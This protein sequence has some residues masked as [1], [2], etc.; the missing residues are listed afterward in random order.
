M[1][2]HFIKLVYTQIL[3][4]IFL[5]TS[6]FLFAQ[7]IATSDNLTSGDKSSN[8]S[9]LTSTNNRDKDDNKSSISSNLTSTNNR[10]KNDDKSSNSSNLTSTNNRDKNDNKT[11]GVS[12]ESSVNEILVTG[13]RL[14]SQASVDMPGVNIIT[15]DDIENIQPTSV[16]SLLRTLPS[17]SI[18]EYGAGK[19]STIR[20]RGALSEHTL[21]MVD[22][23][24]VND[25]TNI[26]NVADLSTLSL[27]DIE[28][29]EVISDSVSSVGF[30]GMGGVVNI[31]TKK[32]DGKLS[33]TVHLDTSVFLDE[34]NGGASIGAGNDN[35]SYKVSYSKLY[36]DAMSVLTNTA[37]DNDPEI[38]AT[39]RD[40]VVIKI[41]F[42]PIQHFK[43]EFVL[44]YVD[45]FA[46]IDGGGSPNGDN[47][48]FT[49]GSNR[50]ATK[51]TTSYLIKDMFEPKLSFYYTYNQREYRDSF[52]NSSFVFRNNDYISHSAGVDFETN[53]KI[54][55]LFKVLVGTSYQFNM[56][57]L[58]TEESV[59]SAGNEVYDERLDI[60]G[61][62]LSRF[63]V[64][65]EAQA[66]LF[67][68]LTLKLS[69]RVDNSGGSDFFGTYK[70]SALYNLKYLR[71]KFRGTVGT[72][73]NP[74]SLF[75]LFDPI[76]GN[77]GLEDEKSFGYQ[78]GVLSEIVKEILFLSIDFYDNYYKNL[79]DGSSGVYENAGDV[80]I[81]GV[82]VAGEYYPIDTIAIKLGYVYSFPYDKSKQKEMLR[83]PNNK[84]TGSFFWEI[85]SGLHVGAEIAYV[86]ERYD[87]GYI[88]L[89]DYFLLNLNVRYKLNDNIELI[90]KG[91]N[92][93]N[94]DY[95][96]ALGYESYGARVYFGAKFKI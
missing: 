82:E 38:D 79:I 77:R 52:S 8:S 50:V 62:I 30:G 91:T 93:T 54:K 42:Q 83:V 68:S 29:V 5:F 7:E 48:E 81:Y 53:I 57:D 45:M 4:L 56:M 16:T 19:A 40:N 9:N 20:L 33:A 13:S 15:S 89:D 44:N 69:G 84:V 41:A 22:G 88:I 2:F 94:A 3:I 74:A 10:D 18:T 66:Y 72:G 58:R 95:E 59:F 11:N 92:V 85:I 60:D 34:F 24:I 73:Y 96:E 17:V 55:K 39:S 46:D 90:L 23:V 31:V 21:V 65:S 1:L 25:P 80:R 12:D 49:Q 28:R 63:S 71:T 87:S 67:D 37:N 36:V 47:P 43:N 51:Y 76:Y 26:G 6:N 75:Q 86:G 32:G 14:S 61:K 64:F 27:E 35:F 70:V 78:V